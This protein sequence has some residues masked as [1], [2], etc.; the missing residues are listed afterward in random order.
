MPRVLLSQ[1]SL[2]TVDS[3]S[4]LDDHRIYLSTVYTKYIYIFVCISFSFHCMGGVEKR[5]SLG[6]G[7][8]GTLRAD[9][10]RAE[11]KLDYKLAQI[12]KHRVSGEG[13]LEVLLC[14]NVAEKKKKCFFVFFVLVQ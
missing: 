6:P 2:A 3:T 1:S 11:Y 9:F 5:V 12:A 8:P 4:R 7:V 13:S 10:F 14:L